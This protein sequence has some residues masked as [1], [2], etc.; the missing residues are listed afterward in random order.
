MIIKDV[1]S[2]LFTGFKKNDNPLQK[3]SLNDNE[4]GGPETDELDRK[5]DNKDNTRQNQV[6]IDTKKIVSVDESYEIEKKEDNSLGKD[7]IHYFSFEGIGSSFCTAGIADLHY[8]QKI[9]KIG[10]KHAL[11]VIEQLV[12][13]K[14]IEQIDECTWRALMNYREFKNFIENN[15]ELS[16]ENA[17]QITRPIPV[18]QRESKFRAFNDLEEDKEP[19]YLPQ[20]HR[21]VYCDNQELQYIILR[22]FPTESDLYAHE[23]RLLFM[24]YAG[25]LSVDDTIFEKQKFVMSQKGLFNHLLK[26]GY[27]HICTINDFPDCFS[28]KSLTH[29]RK[30]YSISSKAKKRNDLKEAIRKKLPEEKIPEVIKKYGTYFPTQKGIDALVKSNLLVEG[31]LSYNNLRLLEEDFF[32]FED[33]NVIPKECVPITSIEAKKGTIELVSNIQKPYFNYHDSEQMINIPRDGGGIRIPNTID[34]VVNG[35]TVFLNRYPESIFINEQFGKFLLRFYD[36]NKR[37]TTCELYDLHNGQ[38]LV[39]GNYDYYHDKDESVSFFDWE[40]I[41]FKNNYD[42]MPFSF[43]D[44]IW[45]LIIEKKYVEPGKIVLYNY[46]QLIEGDNSNNYYIPSKFFESE[47]ITELFIYLYRHGFITCPFIMGIPVNY[48]SEIRLYD[49]NNEF[50][51]YGIVFEN[52][53]L[54]GSQQF[55]LAKKILKEL[56]VHNH[57]EFIEYVQSIWG[58]GCFQSLQKLERTNVGKVYMKHY[59]HNDKKMDNLRKQY[60]LELMETGDIES[61]WKSEFQLYLTVKEIY[62]K[63][64]FQYRAEWLG[65]QSLDIYIPNLKIGIEYQGIQHFE[66][67]DFFGGEESL[68]YRKEL[69]DKKRELCKNNNI[70]LI[71]WLYDEPI[72]ETLVQEKIDKAIRK[73]GN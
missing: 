11:L 12:K 56:D 9:G 52:E 23:L 16:Y 40:K 37:I 65:Y 7:E 48:L 66:S 68:K 27:I 35:A 47:G 18:E 24:A 61:R 25:K 60:V 43:T 69:D 33:G 44:Q 73:K 21:K 42:V 64:I 53:R 30:E 55:T 14:V 19:I 28:Y 17:D 58:E 13:H 38:Y 46:C 31:E 32:P 5:Y 1:F 3:D 15:P 51:K 71:E 50:E 67:V 8:I 20:Y 49:V 4:I 26:Q 22:S 63:T 10:K 45:K 6:A 54:I 57:K 72:N 39:G 70:T 2:K 41:R 59:F 62:P 34:L 29:I 36:S